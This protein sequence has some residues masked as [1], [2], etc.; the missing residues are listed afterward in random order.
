MR[1]GIFAGA[2]ID[3]GGDLDAVIAAARDTEAQ[4][5][6]SFWLPQIFSY[7]AL[8]LLA[9]IGREVPRVELG[10][11]VIPTY[12]RHPMMLAAQA[13]TTNAATGGRL[14][15]GIGLSHQIVIENMLG[16]SYER[17]ARHMSEYLSILAPLIREG[18]VA[19]DGE[20]LSTH[21]GVA[22]PGSSP[23]PILV[24]ALGPK[25]LE[26]TGRVGDGTVT[27]MTGPATIAD[28]I[29][30]SIRAAAEAA[31]RP[32]PR[33]VS[34]L[35]VMVT[36]DAD[37]A[38]ARAAKAFAIYGQLPAYRAML[39]REGAEGPADVAIVGDEATVKAGIA[40]IA[41]AGA[42][43]FVAAEFGSK[44]EEVTRTRDLLKSLL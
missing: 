16:L 14:A 40:R 9:I 42:T 32:E 37:A 25:M 34:S 30:P 2:V 5:F 22:V 23:C 11:A 19:F 1:I 18:S 15:L 33:V 41:E 4:G 38:R 31:G 36:D 6:A 8:T 26:L 13:L 39:D 3:Q 24:A 44:P 12:P 27:W 20:T 43:D 7:D 17:P 21:A 10:T 29:G 35:P 28:H